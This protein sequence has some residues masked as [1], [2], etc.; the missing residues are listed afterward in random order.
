MMLAPGTQAIRFRKPTN[1]STASK[2]AD[3]SEKLKAGAAGKA[4][5]DTLICERLN[6]NRPP[7]IPKLSVA[8]RLLILIRF[9][10]A[11]YTSISDC[12]E[13]F[14]F[15]EP[16]HYLVHGNGFQTWEYSPQYSIRS[17]FYL[18]IHAF[19]AWLASKAFPLDKRPGFFAIRAMLAFLSSYTEARFCQA[20]AHHINIRAA[21]YFL[22]MSLLSAAMW[23][24]STAYLPSAFA[25]Q[26]ITLAY[27]F[28]LEPV[29]SK[30][31]S[32]QRTFYSCFFLIIAILVG[33]PFVGALALP[34]IYEELAMFGDDEVM[35][36]SRPGWAAGRF[37]RLF[38][39]GVGTTLLVSTPIV[40]VDWLAYGKWIFVP[41]KIVL[42]NVF[43][44]ESGGSELYGTEPTNFYFLNLLLNFNI[45]FPLALLS[46]PSVL[47]TQWFSKTQ[48]LRLGTTSR[49]ANQSSASHLLIIRLIPVYL[50]LAILSQQPHKEERFMQPI[51]TLITFNAA[52]T[53]CLFRGWM[54]DVYI[55]VTS[56]PYRAGRTGVF[57]TA[58][59]T[60]ILMASCISISRMF[61]LQYY[62]HAPLDLMFHFQ[63]NELPVRAI[64]SHPT[65]Y[66][67]LKLNSSMPILEAIEHAEYAVDLGK[68]ATDNLTLCLGESWF[69]FPTHFLVPD[70]INVEFVKSSFTGILPAKFLSK[71]KKSRYDGEK[72]V[73]KTVEAIKYP[74]RFR[75][76]IWRR[77]G[78]RLDGGRFNSK[79]LEE[80]DRYVD[81]NTQCQYFIG[82]NYPDRKSGWKGGEV[83]NDKNW[84]ARKCVK[85]L[86]GEETPMMIRT[87]WLPLGWWTDRRE[88]SGKGLQSFGEMCLYRSR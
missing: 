34:F 80:H 9:S 57:S 22:I 50:W 37:N 58:T 46:I 86:D 81:L 75:H 44:R 68:L 25:L 21:R 6:R 48:S 32:A 12:D 27:S 16:T 3:A 2:A 13:S 49:L 56:S 20:I 40:L 45:L 38:V 72:S 31:S 82:I 70:P 53:L 61:A 60:V 29:S 41:L 65:D 79:N 83:E 85:Y 66:A 47:A 78:T 17:W 71:P 24:A 10:A 11:M 76:R 26:A 55:K 63:Y 39:Y 73:N 33:W 19:P 64:Q 15:W 51:Y 42:Y 84:E 54:E 30:P 59:R 87:L 36:A 18:L 62:Y 8:F 88:K 67:Y 23:N 4:I 43:P 5:K 52:V 77:E 1:S 35:P 28:I 7:W 69:R 14:N 74:A